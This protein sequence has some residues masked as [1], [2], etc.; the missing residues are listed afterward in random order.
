MN[1]EKCGAGDDSG[2]RLCTDG[3]T[4][5]VMG[6][7]RKST[8]SLPSSP[9][10]GSENQ[11]EAGLAFIK[12]SLKAAMNEARLG[13]D[14]LGSSRLIK[15]LEEIYNTVAP[16]LTKRGKLRSPLLPPS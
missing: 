7:K 10:E 5:P 12:S 2:L 3:E 9:V 6:V 16:M 13:R 14:N 4:T 1:H 8:I 11:M 15:M